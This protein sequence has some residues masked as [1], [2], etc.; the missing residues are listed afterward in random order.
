MDITLAVA[1]LI[2]MIIIILIANL[3]QTFKVTPT[4]GIGCVCVM[5]GAQAV[6]LL[7]HATVLQNY[8]GG[9]AAGDKGAPGVQ[10][11]FPRSVQWVHTGANTGAYTATITGTTAD[12]ATAQTEAISVTGAGTFPSNKAWAYI[13]NINITVGIHAADSASLQM[14]SKIGIPYKIYAAADLLYVSKT[15]ALGTGVIM[16][17]ASFTVNTT[18][19]TIAETGVNVAAGDIYCYYVRHHGAI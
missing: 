13:T 2:S 8:P 11:D 18:Y 15:A 3:I 14:A 17:P 19:S 4:A 5:A 16:L 7:A 6:G 10:N 12:G 9:T 1:I